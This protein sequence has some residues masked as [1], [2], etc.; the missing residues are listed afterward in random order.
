MDLTL[1]EDQELIAGTAREMLAAK[2]GSADARAVAASPAGYST[3]LWKEMVELGWMGLGFDESYGGV[4]L[5]FFEVCLVIEE[6]G[7]ARTP[8]PFLSTVAG[9]GMPIA[10][11]GAEEQKSEWLGAIARGRVISP[12]RAA[13]HGRWGAAGSDVVATNS[14]DGFVLDGAAL[15]VPYGQ[16]AEDFLVVAQG[17][18]ADELTVLLVDAGSAG[19]SCEPVRA[20]GAG[21]I[22]TV[23]FSQVAVTGDRVLGEAGGGAAVAA[24]MDAYGAAASCVEMV[25]G[26]QAVL[27]MTVEYATQRKQF[28]KPVG[29]FQAVQHH[30]ADMAIDVL[31]SRYIGYEAAWRLS[32]GQDAAMEVST[33]KAWVSEAYQR[34]CARGHQVHGAIGFTAE[35][36]LRHYFEHAHASALAFGDADHH[37]EQLARGLG[38]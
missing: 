12:V 31:G 6:L 8:A 37:N 24:A 9:C 25:G 3:E 2:R 7:R 33:A 36:D 35:H 5:G 15:F 10:R 21:R 29:S 13:P 19:I 32:A 18:R 20:V 17:E 22:C 28:D 16:A 34:V 11:F 1:T 38:L 14:G 27:D 4:G 26:A 30:C 23:E